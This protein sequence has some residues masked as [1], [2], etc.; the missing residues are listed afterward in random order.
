MVSS[1]AKSQE[2][3]PITNIRDERKQESTRNNW[4]NN[5]SSATSNKEQTRDQPSINIC[6]HADLASVV[7][8]PSQEILLQTISA[9]IALKAG[10]MPGKLSKGP[11]LHRPEDFNY[12]QQQRITPDLKYI[13]YHDFKL[14]EDEID[15]IFCRMT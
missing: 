13:N 2:L 10:K 9:D 3:Q 6:K 1:S 5:Q 12:T 15:I 7:D 14:T 4:F 8:N 11:W